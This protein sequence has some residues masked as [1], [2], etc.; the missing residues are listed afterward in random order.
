MHIIDAYTSNYTDECRLNY[1]EIRNKYSI[2][3][4]GVDF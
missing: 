4:C 2:V 3:D 1:C